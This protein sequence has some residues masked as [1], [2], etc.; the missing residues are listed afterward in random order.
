MSERDLSFTKALNAHIFHNGSQPVPN[1]DNIREA[2]LAFAD[3]SPADFIKGDPPQVLLEA[4][5]R[6]KAYGEYL[7]QLF[8]PPVDKLTAEIREVR[9]TDL[10]RGLKRS[11]I[12]KTAKAKTF[13]SDKTINV[14]EGSV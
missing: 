8:T 9:Q 13:T 11:G 14:E 4:A 3:I 2:Q 12:T 5:L 7:D 1:K 10:Q 6:W